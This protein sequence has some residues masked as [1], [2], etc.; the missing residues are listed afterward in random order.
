MA[1]LM[2]HLDRS[3]F[4]L[5]LCLFDASGPYLSSLPDEVAVVHLH[6]RSKWDFLRLVRGLARLIDELK[7]D[8][9]L[10]KME[11]PNIVTAVARRLCRINV[12]LALGE[13]W[14]L[15]EELKYVSHP[16]TRVALLKWAYRS[17]EVVI[18]P[19]KGTQRI[20]HED[21]AIPLH[22][23]RVIP[24]MV[25]LADIQDRSR[26]EHRHGHVV[27]RNEAVIVAAGRLTLAKGFPYLL[28]AIKRV[29]TIVPSHLVI[30]GEGE[31]RTSLEELTRELEIAEGV[32]FM[33]FQENPFPLMINADLFVLSSLWESFGNV[34]IEAMAL[35]VPVIS[36]RAPY[37]PEDIIEHGETGWLVPT[38]DPDAIAAGILRLLRDGEL[39]RRL[40]R[41]GQV[42]ARRFDVAAV[43]PLYEE[44]L[45]S[46]AGAEP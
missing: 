25:D 4:D 6:K 41:A 10:A 43:V 20:L 31:Q 13:E 33:G 45:S 36:T 35:G 17:A 29:E 32:S 7:P 3:R 14:N 9:I 26:R 12:P 30:L 5:T 42:A 21:L 18:T 40:S 11:Y 22:S 15:R 27:R 16:R 8:M 34:L 23:L 28:R 37:G 1:L 38:G 44:V 46:T 2:R 39:R 19:S 24:N